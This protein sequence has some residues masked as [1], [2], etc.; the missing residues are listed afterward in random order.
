VPSASRYQ[1]LLKDVH[2]A[3][4]AAHWAQDRRAEEAPV[5]LHIELSRNDYCS[6]ILS[7]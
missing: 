1:W 4:I 6:E 5:K 2:H 7:I 3:G